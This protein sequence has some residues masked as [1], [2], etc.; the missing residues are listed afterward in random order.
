MLSNHSIQLLILYVSTLVFLRLCSEDNCTGYRCNM[1]PLSL[2][3]FSSNSDFVT[4]KTLNWQIKA[5]Q[6]VSNTKTE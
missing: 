6:Q 4:Q 3:R 1:K 2:L 5:L